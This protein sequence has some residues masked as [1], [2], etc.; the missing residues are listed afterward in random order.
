M[1]KSNKY[2]IGVDLGGTYIKFG[3]VTSEGVIEK[4]L[5]L[6]AHVENGH[7]P[8]VNDILEGVASIIESGV[9]VKGIG[10]GS[11]GTINPKKGTVD[12]PPNFPNWGVV[13]LAK[14]IEKKSGIETFIENDANA[15]AM[16]E[17]IFGAG[18][19]YKSF[20]LVTLGTGVGGG[21]ILK[22]KIFRGEFGAA[23]EIGHMSINQF[24]GP[25]CNC[26]SIGCIEAYL[27]NKHLVASVIKELPAHTSSKIF[28]LID[29]NFD[30]LS[31]RIISEAAE[32]G[33]EY[34]KSVIVDCG[35]KLG[36]VLSAACNL[37][38]VS[39]IIVGGGVAGFGSVL[40]ESAEQSAKSRVLE[41]IRPRVKV[42][43]AELKNDAGILGAA[44]LVFDKQK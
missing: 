8:V 11:P 5:K 3:L 18:R 30:N 17:L 6:K 23:G 42:I 19:N 7:E 21:I 24:T 26:G 43:H 4:K 14:I 13:P 2:A 29:H 39:T 33:D 25:K 35:N 16:G 22:N 38:D 20:I 9:K 36:M 31:P 10:I 40:L 15:A 27:G 41:S 1:V 12:T 37:L 32:L 34:A 44:S 28:E